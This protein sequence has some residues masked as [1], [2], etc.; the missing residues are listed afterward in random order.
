MCNT[1]WFIWLFAKCKTMNG[2]CLCVKHTKFNH[3]TIP[4]A[5]LISCNDFKWKIDTLWAVQRRRWWW[6]MAYNIRIVIYF[7]NGGTI[8]HSSHMFTCT[9]LNA[10]AY[11]RVWIPEIIMHINAI[12]TQPQRPTYASMNGML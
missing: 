5:I 12:F 10:F 6:L 9:F 11:T 8:Q 7:M 3:Y 1:C 4:Q 2:L